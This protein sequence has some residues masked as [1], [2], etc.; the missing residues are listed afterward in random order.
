MIVCELA[1]NP[2]PYPYPR[3]S[4]QNLVAGGY[5]TD[6]SK[7]LVD[8]GKSILLGF[9]AGRFDHHLR[10]LWVKRRSIGLS[11]QKLAK[12]S[13]EIPWVGKV[14]RVDDWVYGVLKGQ[15]IS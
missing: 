10:L 7:T 9:T 15:V 3:G 5:K 13:G 11:G 1:T 14:S 8:D 6:G 4:Y 2:Y 12:F